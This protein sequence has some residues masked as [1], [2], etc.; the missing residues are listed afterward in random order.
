MLPAKGNYQ[1][2]FKLLFILYLTMD[3][4]TQHFQKFLPG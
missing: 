4:I 3:K 1:Y 2:I